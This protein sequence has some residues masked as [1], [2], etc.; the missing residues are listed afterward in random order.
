[1]CTGFATYYNEPLYGMNFDF[2]NVDLKFS[3]KKYNDRKVFMFQY[4]QKQIDIAV[5]GMNSFGVFANYQVLIPNNIEDYH[6]FYEPTTA[7]KNLLNPKMKVFQTIMPKILKTANSVDDVKSYIK[8]NKFYFLPFKKIYKHHSL[9]ADQNESFIF[10]LFNSNAVILPME[11]KYSVISNFPHVPFKET[12]YSETYGFN[13]EAYKKAND[14]IIEQRGYFNVDKAMKTLELSARTN[15][16]FKTRA[17]IVFI[18][19][20]QKVII[21]FDGNYQNIWKINITKN[22]IEYCDVD[23]IVRSTTISKH[24]ILKSEM[25]RLQ[26][27]KNLSWN[28]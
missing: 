20:E 25:L 9:Y 18:P 4:K 7:L 6:L 27:E 14:F 21:C 11:N 13:S 8:R 28:C 26:N 15:G 10:E 1:M 3:I 2:L 5:A 24:G 22:T 16:E 12:K 23:N 19:L 17:S